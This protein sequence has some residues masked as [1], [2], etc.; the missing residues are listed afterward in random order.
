MRDFIDG[1]QAEGLFGP[2]EIRI[3]IGAFEDAWKTLVAS[4][5]PFSEERYR[6]LARE[7]LAKQ[8]IDHARTGEWDQRRLTEGALLKLA[9]SHLK[10]ANDPKRP[11]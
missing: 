4:S 5:A 11:S 2:N 7:I 9:H 1:S 10:H 8:I 6:Q 3:L